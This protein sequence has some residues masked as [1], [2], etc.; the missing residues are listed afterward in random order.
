MA[1]LLNETVGTSNYDNL[2]VDINPPADVVAVK[3][4]AG[5][6]ERGTIITGAAG[7]NLAKLAAA[8]NVENATFVLCDDVEAEAGEVSFAYRSGHF[9]AG[10]LKTNGTYTLTAADKEAL[11]KAGIFVSDAM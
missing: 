1:K 5:S 3:L 6:Y 8:I 7:G 4:A 10:A 9:N 11:R 2:I